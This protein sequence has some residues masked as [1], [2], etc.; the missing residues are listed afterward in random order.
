[1][2]LITEVHLISFLLVDAEVIYSALYGKH[3]CNEP[4][5]VFYEFLIF[6]YSSHPPWCISSVRLCKDER[7]VQN[8]LWGLSKYSW[9]CIKQYNIFLV[10]LKKMGL[11]Q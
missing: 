8:L 1:M 4:L 11:S 2:I 5:Y 7:G 3:L 9:N 6:F 10:G